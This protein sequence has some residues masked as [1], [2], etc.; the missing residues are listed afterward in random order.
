MEHSISGE[1]L[2]RLVKF[3]EYIDSCPLGE[4]KWDEELGYYCSRCDGVNGGERVCGREACLT[5]RR[6]EKT[7][8]N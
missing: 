4:I 2:D 8:E 3:V 6:L 7:G 1:I 5:A